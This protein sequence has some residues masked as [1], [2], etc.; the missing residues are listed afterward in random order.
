MFKAFNFELSEFWSAEYGKTEQP[1]RKFQGRRF[2]WSGTRE[3]KRLAN[4]SLFFSV[5]VRAKVGGSPSA[6]QEWSARGSTCSRHGTSSRYIIWN[7]LYCYTYIQTCLLDLKALHVHSC[8]EKLHILNCLNTS[9]NFRSKAE[10]LQIFM[11]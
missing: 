8:I 5:W 7:Q 9:S 10:N 6:L 1:G 11:F 3:E 4:S 2:L